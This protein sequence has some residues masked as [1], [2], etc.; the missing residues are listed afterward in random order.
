M[1][2]LQPEELLPLLEGV[3]EEIPVHCNGRSALLVIRTQRVL[4]NGQDMSAS[5]FELTCGKGDAK[6]WKCSLWLEDE[7]GEPVMVCHTCFLGC[8]FVI[9]SCHTLLLLS[10]F[11]LKDTKADF[12]LPPP[13][14]PPRSMHCSLGS[15]R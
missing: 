4:F 13:P 15:S 8:S 5:K 1:L 9:W 7:N 3:P 14:P 6:K 10:L 12:L 2:F 11:L